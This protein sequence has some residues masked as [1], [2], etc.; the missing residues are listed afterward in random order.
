LI[1]DVASKDSKLNGKLPSVAYVSGI[2]QDRFR[3][4][5]G[6]D[7]ITTIPSQSPKTQIITKAT[8]A[9]S[10][11]FQIIQQVAANAESAAEFNEIKDYFDLKIQN[12]DDN[13]LQF[14]KEN[15][16]RYPTLS[17]LA[18]KYLAM[19]ASSGSVERL[20]SV[21]GAIARPRRASLKMESLEKILCYR[22]HLI[23]NM[24]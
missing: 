18:Q 6:K 7:D 8:V 11:K 19:P 23:N 14:W 4:F 1:A 12:Q 13:P 22:Q 21:A 17:A 24:K 16:T 20:F 15:S 10:T 9:K 2:L 5:Q 3:N